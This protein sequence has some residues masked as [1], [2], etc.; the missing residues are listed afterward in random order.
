M[1]LEVLAAWLCERKMK[2]SHRVR[3]NHRQL[4]LLL[5]LLHIVTAFEDAHCIT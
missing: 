5:L 4:R 3:I 1:A 2:F